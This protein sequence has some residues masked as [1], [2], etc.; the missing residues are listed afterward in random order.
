MARPHNPRFPIPILR[1][2]YRPGQRE[3]ATAVPAR[4][5]N[6]RPPPR[7]EHH[8]RRQPPPAS[9]LRQIY[10]STTQPIAPLTLP[11][12]LYHTSWP[13]I[14]RNLPSSRPR[15]PSLDLRIQ[16]PPRSRGSEVSWPLTCTT[17][18]RRLLLS[19][20]SNNNN[21]S[22]WTPAERSSGP[23][24]CWKPVCL[25]LSLQHFPNVF[26]DEFSPMSVLGLPW[27]LENIHS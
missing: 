7:Q 21:N 16:L 4:R 12:H 15:L 19:S 10:N 26:C 8:H 24:L 2:S 23:P 1:C 22:V 13:S 5:A 18:L 3:G 25:H 6:Q 9:H 27:N 11:V 20:S 17:S 14:Q